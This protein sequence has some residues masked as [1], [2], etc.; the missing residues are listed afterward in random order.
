MKTKNKKADVK[1]WIVILL[2]I[3]IILVLALTF[4]VN[5]IIVNKNYAKMGSEFKIIQSDFN[6]N[7]ETYS[8]QMV[9]SKSELSPFGF[10][11]NTGYIPDKSITQNFKVAYRDIDFAYK[12]DT[13]SERKKRLELYD[14]GQNRPISDRTNRYFTLVSE[15]D[16]NRWIG[17]DTDPQKSYCIPLGKDRETIKFIWR[18]IVERYDGDTD[19]GCILNGSTDCYEAGDGLYPDERARENI[20]LYPINNW[21]IENEIFD[22]YVKCDYNF[23]TDSYNFPKAPLG[24]DDRPTKEET[25]EYLKEISKVIREANSGAKV[26]F[27]SFPDA[28]SVLFLDGRIEYLDSYAPDCNYPGRVN[29]TQARKLIQSGAGKNILEYSFWLKDYTEYLIKEGYDYYDMLDFHDYSNDPY[30]NRAEME[31]YRDILGN[32]LDSKRV[33][34]TE[35]SG[36]WNFFLFIDGASKPNCENTKE[37]ETKRCNSQPYDEGV[38]SE[39]VI[40]RCVVGLSAGMSTFFW[41]TFVELIEGFN[42]NF[43]RLGL[44][45]DLDGTWEN[46]GGYREKPAYYT[47]LLMLEKLYNF[48]SIQELQRDVYKFS[49]VDKNPVYVAWS[50]TGNRTIDLSNEFDNGDVKIT[51][52]ITEYGKTEKNAVV[53]TI[54]AENIKIARRPI[55]IEEA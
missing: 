41:A 25:L 16:N 31:W 23:V 3:L 46:T 55:F 54:S 27:P 38:L 32:K 47:S 45:V 14:H 20:K 36:P 26:V 7:F 18:M 19:Y 39:F 9:Y 50:E 28:R 53:E 5:K 17:K 40:K 15:F 30:V 11:Y 12:F 52:I 2:I 29:I 6:P 24:I 43:N 44:I 10:F 33:I 35:N 21:Q 49:F 1:T 51:H 37:C 48:T 34:S 8:N 42:D 22:Q 4:I 13:T